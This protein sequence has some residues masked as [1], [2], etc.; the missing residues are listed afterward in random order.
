MNRAGSCFR[1][2]CGCVEHVGFDRRHAI[3]PD[4]GEISLA[5]LLTLGR[6]QLL[7]RPSVTRAENGRPP[8][9]R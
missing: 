8:I 6:L 5:N 1:L 2:D 9:F 7:K 3:G 4:R